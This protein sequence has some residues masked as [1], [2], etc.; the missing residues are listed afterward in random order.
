[1]SRYRRADTPGAT[2]FFT[3]TLL[4]ADWGLAAALEGQYGE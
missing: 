3:A 2:C 4:P 1:M